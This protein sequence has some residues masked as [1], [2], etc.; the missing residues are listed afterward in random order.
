MAGLIVNRKIGSP[1]AH[2]RKEDGVCVGVSG[3]GSDSAQQFSTAALGLLSKSFYCLEGG[4]VRW[5][6]EGGEK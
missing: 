2:S 5:K 4:L 3:H 6:L 1:P